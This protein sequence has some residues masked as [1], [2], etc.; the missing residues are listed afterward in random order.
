[1]LTDEVLASSFVLKYQY[2]RCVLAKRTVLAHKNTGQK[3]SNT[4]DNYKLMTCVGRHNVSKAMFINRWSTV[5]GIIF[6]IIH[7][8]T[9]GK[10]WMACNSRLFQFLDSFS[11]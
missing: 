5:A 10:K 7:L 1:M 2:L 9:A 8:T 11:L 3:S 6:D 4:S